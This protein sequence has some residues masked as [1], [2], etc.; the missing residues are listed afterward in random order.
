[1]KAL[2][3]AVLSMLSLNAFATSEIVVNTKEGTVSVAWLGSEVDESEAELLWEIDGS[4]LALT[5]GD[6]CFNGDAQEVT[7]IFKA[8][9]DMDI[10]GDEYPFQNIKVLNNGNAIS[11]EVLD[12]PNEYVVS[13]PTVE[14]CK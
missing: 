12:G 7:Q 9:D 10:L 13:N 5:Y 14:R 8:L 6:L 11:Y 2:T 3:F 4:V 1:M